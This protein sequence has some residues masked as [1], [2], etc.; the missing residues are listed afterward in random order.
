MKTSQPFFQPEK[1]ADDGRRDQP[2]PA[3]AGGVGRWE[4]SVPSAAAGSAN[5]LADDG[6]GDGA[7]A[8]NHAGA[9]PTNCAGDGAGASNRDGGGAGLTNRAGDGAGATNR[10]LCWC[11]V[12]W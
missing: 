2:I 5:Q 6:A 9:G 7:G 1:A 11:K 8:T 3:G 12:R 4:R 10:H